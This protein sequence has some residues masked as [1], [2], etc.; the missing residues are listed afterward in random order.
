M[1]PR[2]DTIEKMIDSPAPIENKLRILYLYGAVEVLR[3]LMDKMTDETKP[4]LIER[5]Y[6]VEEAAAILETML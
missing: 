6:A 1:K 2:K 4:L 3:A 5:I